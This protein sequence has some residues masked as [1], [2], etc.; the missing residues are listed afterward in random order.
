M[1][2]NRYGF[3]VASDCVSGCGLSDLAAISTPKLY[4]PDRA[5]LQAEGMV[6]GWS[7][8]KGM[9]TQDVVLELSA[10]IVV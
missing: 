3:G 8:V 9:Q 2:A 4:Q 6:L 10:L 5:L 7:C 1:W